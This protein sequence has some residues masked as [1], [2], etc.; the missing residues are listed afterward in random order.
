MS[1]K[2]AVTVDAEPIDVVINIKVS[3]DL[4]DDGTDGQVLMRVGG[5]NVWADPPAG[6]GGGIVKEIDPTVPAWAKQ[7][8]KP[9]YTAEE[10]GA[11]PK[12]N[13]ALRNEIPTVPAWAKQ[14][15]KPTYTAEEVG[16]ASKG[17]VEQ[18]SKEVADKQPKGDYALKSEIPDAPEPYTLPVASVYTLG[19]VKVDGFAK[20][21]LDVKDGALSLH[22]TPISPSQVGKPFGTL[23]PDNVTDLVTNFLRFGPICIFT[24]Q[25]RVHTAIQ[26]QEYGFEVAELPYTSMSRIWLNNATA[27]YIDGYGVDAKGIRVNGVWLAENTYVLSGIYFTTDE[28]M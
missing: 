1:D 5:K 7:P 21:W 16:A 24:Y 23:Y 3:G 15:N 25:F 13:Y 2:L 12:G 27:F 9:T 19:G 10:V 14:P 17:D 4:P 8:H 6:P 22:T 28:V 11:Q 20:S 18:L 26:D